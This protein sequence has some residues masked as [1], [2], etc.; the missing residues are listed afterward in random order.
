MEEEG[1]ERFT[2]DTKTAAKTQTYSL[3]IGVT[4]R[5]AAVKILNIKPKYYD[6]IKLERGDYH[7]YV[8][9]DGYKPVS[10]WI[11]IKQNEYINIALEKNIEIPVAQKTSPV[12]IQSTQASNSSLA[13]TSKPDMSSLP[14]TERNAIEKVCKPQETFYGPASYYNCIREQMNALQGYR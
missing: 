1:I 13:R 3:T 10:R 4:P 11:N 2:K 7:I 8:V 9:K 12:K 14:Q 6:G 5:D